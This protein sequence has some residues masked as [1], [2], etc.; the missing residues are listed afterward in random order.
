M[1]YFI[2][3]MTICNQNNDNKYVFMVLKI[4]Q[5]VVGLQKTIIQILHRKKH[6]YV[7]YTASKDLHQQVH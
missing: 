6:L 1:I 7:L 4:L 2:E 5:G 3:I